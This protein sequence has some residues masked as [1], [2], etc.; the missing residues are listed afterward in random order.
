MILQ[1][2]REV[3]EAYL[4]R[5]NPAAVLVAGDKVAS[6]VAVGGEAIRELVAR[7][8]LP[9]PVKKGDAAPALELPDLDGK[10]LNLSL[11]PGQSTMLLFWSPFCGFCQQILAGLKEWET[12][13]PKEAPQLLVISTGPAE[14]NRAQGFQSPVLLDKYFV[15]GHIFGADGT[16]SAV[17]L[18]E[19][20][21]LASE[22]VVGGKEAL[23]LIGARAHS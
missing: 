20:G 7:A 22:L 17:M 3:A 19:A 18:D 6:P 9:S 5:A 1:Q 13:R 10:L 15:A 11:S 4:V 12:N 23:A 21:R 14:V 2:N 16:P 8:T